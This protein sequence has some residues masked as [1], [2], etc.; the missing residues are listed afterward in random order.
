[1]SRRDSRTA[2]ICRIELPLV[3]A[4]RELAAEVTPWSDSGLETIFAVRLRW[5]R[6]PIVPQ[7][8]IAGHRVDFL[9]G[10]RV[11]VQLDGGHHVGAQRAS[12]IAHDAELALLGY[13]VIRVTYGQ[14]MGRWHEVQDRI[15]RAVAQ[16]L[17]LAR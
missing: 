8:W 7:A 1:M 5:M 9:I 11:V 16:G 15:M 2:G 10:D 6:L 12:D 4:A 13:T 14:V 17:H 3:G